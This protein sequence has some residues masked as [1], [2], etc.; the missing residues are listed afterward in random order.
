VRADDV[1]TLLDYTAWANRQILA[2]ARAAGPDAFTA[3][4]DVTYRNIRATLVHTLDVERSWRDRIR[5]LP[6]ERW[7]S[8]L[9]ETEFAT[10]DDLEARW[11]REDTELRAWLATLDDEA[12]A[13]EVDL[14][15][16]DRFPL[17]YFLVHVVTHSAQQRRDAVTLLTL[18]GHPPPE[19]EFLNY[20][21]T[22]GADPTDGAAHSE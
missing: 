14:G 17:W 3:P 5:G 18:A 10:V 6:G 13:A 22:L 9:S 11:D 19:I 8:E 7:G 15:P 2:A 1:I 20:A 16:K 4:T 12:M 21:D